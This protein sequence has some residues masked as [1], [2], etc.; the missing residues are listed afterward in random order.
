M[1]CRVSQVEERAS[2]NLTELCCYYCVLI[3]LRR[4]LGLGAVGS[5][6]QLSTLRDSG[7]SSFTGILGIFIPVG[8][9]H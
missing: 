8:G 6:K 4:I 1:L 9:A 7:N 3:C 5:I 2:N